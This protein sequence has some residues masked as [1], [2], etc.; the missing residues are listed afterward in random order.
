M[1][2]VTSHPAGIRLI[3]R[4]FSLRERG[5]AISIRQTAVPLGG[6]IG[7]LALPSLASVAG[8]R[9]GLFA[10]GLAA[11]ALAALAWLALPSDDGVDAGGPRAALPSF[12]RVVSMPGVL[13]GVAISF[14][15]NIGQVAVVTFIALFAH[16]GLGHSVA[17]GVVLLALVQGSGI[18]GRILWGVLSDRAYGG[19]RRPLLALLGAGAVASVGALALATDGTPVAALVV[20]AGAAGLTAVAWNGL[21][22]ALTT[23]A[24]GV[25]G[26]AVAMSCTVL[27]VSFVNAALPLAGGLLVDATGSYRTV[28]L[29]AAAVLALS[30]VLTLLARERGDLR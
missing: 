19:R 15:L 20:I 22:I 23:E 24:A 2:V 16:D 18:A 9:A 27:V 1:G 10:V 5:G 25:A 3:M 26:A 21:A 8:W 4:H 12:A 14:S 6:A 7:A 11:L 29:A 17:L 30:P 28:W 13:L